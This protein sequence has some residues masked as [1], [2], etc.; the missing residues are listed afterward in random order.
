MWP[1]W[2]WN[3]GPLTYEPGALLNAL[4]GPAQ[5]REERGVGITFHMLCPRYSGPINPT[6]PTASRLWETFIFA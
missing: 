1:D 6:A 5:I 3:P 2:V 4:R